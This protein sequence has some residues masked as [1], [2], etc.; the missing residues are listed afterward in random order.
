MASS[1]QIPTLLG[2]GTFSV[3]S[4][5]GLFDRLLSGSTLYER[6]LWILVLVVLLGDLASTYYGLQAGLVEHNPAGATAIESLGYWSLLFMKL[7]AITVGLAC[8]E[9]LPGRYTGLVPLG[10]AIPWL[11]ATLHNVVLIALVV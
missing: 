9:G 1:D 3:E 5:W 6:E 2:Y 8:R 11:I 4:L 10:L 7:I